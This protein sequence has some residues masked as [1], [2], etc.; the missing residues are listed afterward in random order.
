MADKNILLADLNVAQKAAV[1]HK[2]G[3]LLIIAGAGSGKTRVLTYRVAQLISGG[4]KPESILAMTFTNKAANEMKERVAKLLQ[5]PASAPWI[6]TFHS[7]GAWILRHEHKA[8]GISKN[9][10]IIDE[11][12]RLALVKEAIKELAVDPKQFPPSKIKKIISQKKSDLVGAE[13]FS[14]DAKDRFSKTLGDV[15]RSYEEKLKSSDSLD[16]DDLLVRTVSLFSGNAEVLSKYQ[17]LWQYV[18]IDEYQDTDH[19]QYMLANALASKHSNICAVGDLDQSIYSFRGAD[20]RNILNFEASW[21]KAKVI[22]L[23]ENYRSSKPILDAANAVISENKLR[24]PKN[25]FTKKEGGEKLAICAAENENDEADF[26][27]AKISELAKNGVKPEEIAVLFRTNAQSRVLEEKF[28]AYNLPY[29]VV[30]VKF[31]GRKEIKDVLAYLRA[32]LNSSDLLSKK[33]I[34]NSPARGIGKALLVKYLAGSELKPHEREKISGFEKNLAKIKTL[35]E[36]LPA[37]RAVAGVLKESGYFDMFDA[38]TEEGLMRLANIKELVSL[39]CRF[40]ELSPPSGII[41]ML[42]EASLMS[43]QDSLDGKKKGVPL[44][45]VHA[46]K[47][48]EFNYVFIAGLEDGLFPHTTIGGEDEKLRLEEERRL[49]Y[50]ALTRARKKIYLS[51]AFFRTIFGEKQVNMPSRFLED[52]PPDLLEKA[53]G[54]K[55]I[56][57]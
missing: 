5:Y 42:E 2:D 38:D 33:R 57:L 49:F 12:D 43:D 40:D 56:E 22:T 41:K 11:E 18:N 14:S 53:D 50:V 29:H 9:F 36:K 32:G 30:G 52:I 55:T 10:S 39:S 13:N 1:L 15:W 51:L 27:A 24:R 21:P 16:F 46:A 6:G 23:E 26:I 45:T 34:I 19:V 4:I 37:S 8:A 25:L 54:E 48:L 28:L 47:G 7:L 35:A 17:D 3:P 31:Y 44:T 20:F